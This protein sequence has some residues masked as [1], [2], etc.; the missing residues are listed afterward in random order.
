MEATV[1][2]ST[3]ATEPGEEAVA[4]LWSRIRDHLKS[5]RRRIAREIREYPTPIAG[6]DA[7]FNHLLQERASVSEELRCVHEAVERG[8]CDAR[9]LERMAEWART[10]RHV[11][12]E[13]RQAID[14]SLAAR[15]SEIRA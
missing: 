7:Q 14:A 9:T 13:L 6:C 11:D 15:L 10:S 4:R 1:P 8:R 2:Q 5:E 12:P 3:G